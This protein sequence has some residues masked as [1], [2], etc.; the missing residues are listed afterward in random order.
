MTNNRN[1]CVISPA[2]HHHL[3]HIPLRIKHQLKVVH[4]ELHR[5]VVMI[6]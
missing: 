5:S 6:N 2:D 3:Y 1:D 4:H